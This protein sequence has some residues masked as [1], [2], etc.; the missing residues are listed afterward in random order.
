[1]RVRDV[2]L[3]AS[4]AARPQA[5]AFGE[6]AYG[7]LALEA[8]VLLDSLINHPLVDGNKRL[9]WAAVVVF[10]ELNERDLAPPTQ[11][12]TFEFVMSVADGR[13]GGDV[14]EVA[15]VL[16]EWARPF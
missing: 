7:S 12:A 13:L 5:T 16:S 11:D 2:G 10:F 14:A 1:M 8:A 3:P 6:D 15:S 4:A 9:G